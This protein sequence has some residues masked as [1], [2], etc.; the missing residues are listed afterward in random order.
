MSPLITE[1][2]KVSKGQRGKHQGEDG[3]REE[4]GAF[5]GDFMLIFFCSF[6]MNL[7]GPF[8]NLVLLLQRQIPPG[9]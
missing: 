9:S 3:E 1:S 8:M 4:L 2:C 6:N 7:L 5:L